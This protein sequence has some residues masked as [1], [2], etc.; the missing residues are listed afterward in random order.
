[1]KDN[2]EDLLPALENAENDI[3]SELKSDDSQL[4]AIEASFNALLF[5]INKLKDHASFLLT[6]GSKSKQK[7]GKLLE[8]ADE[9]LDIAQ[10]WKNAKEAKDSARFSYQYNK[11]FAALKKIQDPSF[12]LNKHS[13]VWHLLVNITICAT[14]FGGIVLGL[15]YAITGS[16]FF[17]T[18]SAKLVNSIEELGN[19]FFSQCKDS[20]FSSTSFTALSHDLINHIGLFVADEDITAFGHVDKSNSEIFK[21]RLEEITKFH[22]VVQ[23]FRK[24]LPGKNHAVG[25]L[26][27]KE[28]WEFIQAYSTILK[29]TDWVTGE[30]A[31]GL[32]NSF[33]TLIDIVSRSDL[34]SMNRY[35]EYLNGE[36]IN[37]IYIADKFLMETFTKHGTFL[38]RIFWIEEAAKKGF[39]LA[40][41]DLGIQSGEIYLRYTGYMTEPDH[42]YANYCKTATDALEEAVKQFNLI[43]DTT[44]IKAK[45]K[46]VNFLEEPRCEA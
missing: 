36:D 13:D 24:K 4:L 7:G 26:N 33:H 35:I 30:E 2:V 22:E 21:T 9:F 8:K 39:P 44:D 45:E 41:C 40:I 3:S 17:P 42:L 25:Y 14:I 6:Q 16:G 20:D 37:P 32:V 15:K 43:R 46:L 11:F 19:N 31:Y 38:Q 27:D 1:M 10:K 23:W 28:R 29:H 34:D 5:N 18:T 12:G